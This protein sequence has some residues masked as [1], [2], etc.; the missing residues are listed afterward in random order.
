MQHVYDIENV[1]ALPFYISYGVDYGLGRLSGESHDAAY[2]GIY[3]EQRAYSVGDNYAQ[4]ARP[5][6]WPW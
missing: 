4:E 1:G 2:R 3:W 6:G 5:R